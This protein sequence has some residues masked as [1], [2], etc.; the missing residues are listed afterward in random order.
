MASNIAPSVSRE[1]R[2]K[3]I[4]WR[5]CRYFHTLHLSCAA[6]TISWLLSVCIAI[7][8]H[9]AKQEVVRRLRVT[10]C[11]YGVQAKTLHI[12]DQETIPIKPGY[13]HIIGFER[14]K[15]FFFA[16]YLA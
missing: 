13:V 10:L 7:H 4:V 16:S 11:K 5:L 1:L 3:A 6:H 12:R 8:S 15:K 9:V 2:K 14:K